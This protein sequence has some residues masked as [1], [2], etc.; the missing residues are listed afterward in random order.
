MCLAIPGRL[1]QKEGT[2]GTV[3][4]GGLNKEIDLTFVPEAEI[5]EWLI[6]HTGFGLEIISE[7][8]AKE[9]IELL[10]QAYGNES[11]PV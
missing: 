7:Q 2:K 11:I 8:D 10:Q 3:D 9:T 4:L 6:I 1:V 5:G